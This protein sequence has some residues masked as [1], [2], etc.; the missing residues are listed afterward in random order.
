VKY[1]LVLLIFV[2]GCSP[3]IKPTALTDTRPTWMKTKPYRSGYY[4][5]I[6]HSSKV[7]SSNYIQAAKKSALDDLVSDI[8]VS[9]SSTSVLSILETNKNL[10]EQYEQMIQTTA[11]DEIEEFEVVDA[12]EDEQNYW[13]YYQLSIARYKE[14]KEEQL[15]NATVLAT[16]YYSKGKEAEANTQ[17]PQAINFYFQ[18]L[19]SVEK[20]LGNAIRVTIDSKEVLLVNEIFASLQRTLNRITLRADPQQIQLNRRVQT[21][22]PTVSVWATDK[23]TRTPLQNLPLMVSF[24]KG[25]GSVHPTTHT[26]NQGVATIMVNSISSKEVEQSI[27]VQVNLDQLS[28]ISESAFYPIIAK[29]LNIPKAQIAL[30]VQRPLVYIAAD[31]RSYGNRKNVDQLQNR[32][33]NYLTSNGFEFT[34]Q[35]NSADLVMQIVADTE[36]GS[37]TGSIFVSY[38]TST[39]KV[40]TVG[41]QKEIYATTLDRIKGFGLDYNKASVDAYNKSIDLLQNS[42]LQELLNSILQ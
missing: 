34:T 32:I 1:F 18:A 6:G 25:A 7:T 8:R 13:V 36:Q 15:R 28:G 9:V 33:K 16:D 27:G 19:R 37:V 11:A 21:T 35:R 29:A 3:S 38:L 24:E 30:Q 14:I 12:W 2:F 20:Y 17:L 26:N 10:S 41:E 39:I 23:D 40:S 5:G 22:M 42:I 4:T 31:E